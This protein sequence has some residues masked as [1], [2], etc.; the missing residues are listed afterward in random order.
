MRQRRLLYIVT[1]VAAAAV[2]L[3]LIGGAT[4][5]YWI[6]PRQTLASV[7]GANI[8]RRDYW[9][10]REVQLR[11]QG[12]Q[13]QQQLSFSS[14]SQLA[15]LNQQLAQV[16][17]EIS[18]IQNAPIA[19]DTLSGMVDDQ[20]VL[21]NLGD[22]GI[23]ISADEVNAYLNE[24]FAPVPLTEPTPTPTVEATAAAWATG[25]TEARAAQATG[26]GEASA[27]GA[28]QTATGAAGT[29][30]AAPTSNSTAS[31]TAPATET[32][33]IAV[34]SPTTVGSPASASPTVS[35]TPGASPTATPNAEQAVATSQATFDQYRRF[36][37]NPSNMSRNDY[38]RLIARPALGRQ[39]V[40]EQLAAG[41]PA[42]ADQVR[43]AHILV[44]TKEAA[45]AVVQQLNAGEDF[46]TVAR[47][48]STDTASASNG[49][50]LGW[51][52]RGI[53]VPQFTDQA[54]AL[55]PGQVSQP[56][57]TQF[58]WHIVKVLEKEAN[59]PITITTLQQLKSA[60]FTNWLDTKRGA[61]NISAKIALT[62]PASATN[63]TFTPPPDAPP[64]IV[65]TQPAIVPIPTPG[66]VGTANATPAP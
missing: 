28:A 50:D 63:T 35:G 12:E 62:S 53:M 14:G 18:N 16:R 46:A 61:S 65:P 37:L 20:V 27:T 33:T 38:A 3:I 47:S 54:F 7:N 10:V 57:Q 44:A 9:K 8:A 58:G 19:A 66:P 24:Q 2:L 23:S 43:A 22:L 40:R 29:P 36:V 25:T 55:E 45:D 31:A 34:G 64:T 56:F 15:T 60:S 5:Q 41:V 32:P 59:R 26:T 52:P 42:R 13:L 30:G 11:Q 4:W 49:G 39:K 17:S 51:F 48:V 6:F 21:Q 1:G